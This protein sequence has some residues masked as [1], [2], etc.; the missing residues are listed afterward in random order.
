MHE[1]ARNTYNRSGP[2]GLGSVS[3]QRQTH[4]PSEGGRSSQG[5]E[6]PWS[7]ARSECGLVPQKAV[8]KCGTAF[9]VSPTYTQHLHYYFLINYS[10][11]LEYLYDK[12]F[13]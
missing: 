11:K 6:A 5:R 12:Y 3:T 10:H 4:D 9:L 13:S 2:G 8:P 1:S 7:E